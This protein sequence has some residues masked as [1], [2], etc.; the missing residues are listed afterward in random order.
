MTNG[1]Y[2]FSKDVWGNKYAYIYT[3]NLKNKLNKYYR[4]EYF[5]NKQKPYAYQY[6]VPES[7]YK[8]VLKKIGIKHNQRAK[9]L[10]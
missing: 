1:C 6:C 10:E 4:A 2:W 7:E 9:H 3:E 5:D 8:Q